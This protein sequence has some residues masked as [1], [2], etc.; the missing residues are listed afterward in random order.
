MA[1][2]DDW[3][4][5]DPSRPPLPGASD[6]EERATRTDAVVSRVLVASGVATLVIMTIAGAGLALLWGRQRR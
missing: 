1:P 5:T 4:T 3:M 2:D 6:R